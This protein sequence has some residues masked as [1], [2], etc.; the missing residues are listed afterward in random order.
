M[1]PFT[2]NGTKITAIVGFRERRMASVWDEQ[3]H[4][5]SRIKLGLK[6]EL[7]LNHFPMAVLG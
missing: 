3:G 4:G 2:M 1:C 5:G 6:N 7:A